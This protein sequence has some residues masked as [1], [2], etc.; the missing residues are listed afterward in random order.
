MPPDSTGPDQSPDLLGQIT[1]WLGDRFDEIIR[2]LSDPDSAAA[3]LSE[4]GWEGNA[5]TMPAQLLARVDATQQPGTD[6]G[7][8]TAETLAEFVIAFDALAEA[9]LAA[10]NSVGPVVVAELVADLFD[11]AMAADM[12]QNHPA[13]W[14]LLRLLGL[15]DDDVVQL[16]RVG[17]LVSNPGQYIAIPEGPGYAQRYAAYSLLLAAVAGVIMFFV[18]PTPNDGNRDWL[19]PHGHDVNAFGIDVLYGW[20]PADPAQLDLSDP[21]NPYPHLMEVLTRMLTLRIDLQA[22]GKGMPGIHDKIDF[23]FALVPPE[24]MPAAGADPAHPGAFGLYVRMSGVAEL[25]LPLGRGWQLSLTSPGTPAVEALIVAG[26]GGASFVRG[27]SGGGF[28]TVLALERPADVSGSAV[29]GNKD[30]SHLE[31]EHG[32]VAFTLDEDDARGLLFDFSAHADHVILDI[33]FGSDSFVSA[34]LPPSLRIDTKLGAG[35]EFG[36][37]GR[38]LYLDGGVSLVVDLPVDL[39]ASTSDQ[40]F[41]F[42]IQGLHLRVGPPPNDSGGD[43]RAAFVVAFTVDLLA[44]IFGG[45]ATVAGIGVAATLTQAQPGTATSA[46]RAGRWEP[47]LVSVP[48]KG[49]GLVFDVNGAVKGGGFIG[50]DAAQHEYTGALQLH[51]SSGRHHRPRD[52]RHEDPGHDGDWALLVVITATGFSPGIQRRLR[53]HAHRPRR[54][55]SAINHTHRQRRDRRR[56]ADQ[57]ARRDPVPARPGRRRRRTSSRSGGRP[58]RSSVGHTVVGPMVQLSWGGDDARARSSSAVLIELDPQPGP[59]RAARQ[60]PVRTRRRSDRPLWSGCAPTSSAG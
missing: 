10:D 13:V 28:K 14:A 1:G 24:H 18:K 54:R 37:H 17:D 58:C 29:F 3:V 5:P 42:L 43:A 4:L 33:E 32:R 22:A 30:R 9:L 8:Q 25:E 47:V 11:I 20:A 57:G 41:R 27:T 19:D 44:T 23:T 45:T 26:Q 31:I 39:G 56:A 53:L 60:P 55:R 48:P 16:A 52:A 12:K 46:P 49:V 40:Q 36:K 34:V 21:A 15:L 50:Y 38:G 2:V 35:F 7:S 51:A 59:D 6:S